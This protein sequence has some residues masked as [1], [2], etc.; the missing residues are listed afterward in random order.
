M[1]FI[2]V[3][4]KLRGNKNKVFVEK[5]N[6]IQP[7]YKITNR[8]DL[9]NRSPKNQTYERINEQEQEQEQETDYRG[10]FI[11]ENNHKYD[12]LNRNQRF[13]G[14]IQNNT[15]ESSNPVLK[16]RTDEHVYLDVVQKSIEQVTNQQESIYDIPLPNIVN[17]LQ[18]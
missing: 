7:V 15:Y 18:T 9:E 8:L 6:S 13:I 12:E 2:F 17:N 5:K 10:V 1:F 14:S 11:D 16:T 4:K 3:R